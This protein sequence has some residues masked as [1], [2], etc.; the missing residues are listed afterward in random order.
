VAQGTGSNRFLRLLTSLASARVVLALAAA[1]VFAVSGCGGD[2][3]DETA[4][5]QSSPTADGSAGKESSSNGSANGPSSLGGVGEDGAGA[6]SSGGPQGSEQGSGN[7]QGPRVKIPSG[8]PE[9]GLTPAERSSATVASISLSSPVAPTVPSGVPTLPAAYTCDGKDVWPE[10]RWQGVPS[11]TVELS[12]FAMGVKP[13]D[14]GKL[15]VDW[16]VAGLDPEL[17][18]LEAGQLPQG[19]V[20]G[21]NG[22]GRVGYSICPAL[23]E[24]ETYIFALYALPTRLSPQRGFDPRDLRKRILDV[25]GN[26]GLMAV[27]YARG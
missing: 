20:V 4:S 2:S 27:S 21:R 1:V 5:T 7:K 22:F 16:A 10:L 3:D 23:G 25:S 26:A 8:E 19:A 24:S 17:E 6:A 9:P 12:L 15:F 11:G 13:V 14:D 18:G